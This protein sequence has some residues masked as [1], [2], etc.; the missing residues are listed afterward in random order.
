MFEAGSAAFSVTMLVDGSKHPPPQFM[1]GFTIQVLC[2]PAGPAHLS[3]EGDEIVFSEA[4]LRPH[5]LK[6]L[7][8]LLWVPTR[9]GALP[10]PRLAT[11]VEAF[12]RFPQAAVVQAR[13]GVEA[14]T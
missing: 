5:F 1:R 11:Q 4:I 12:E 2:H 14:A 10:R 9:A 7:P 8:T 3:S 13:R 6:E